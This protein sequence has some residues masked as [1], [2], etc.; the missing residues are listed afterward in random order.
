MT[1]E[2]WL[3]T[4][5]GGGGQLALVHAVDGAVGAHGA[6]RSQAVEDLARLNQ[7]FTGQAAREFTV[8]LQ[9]K[10]ERESILSS[11]STQRTTE[12]TQHIS[13]DCSQWLIY[14][15]FLIIKPRSTQI[16]IVVL[17]Q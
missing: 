13:V 12:L 3:L 11:H 7:R 14:I 9:G 15:C 2:L 5:E 6:A 17:P 1:G 16:V 10:K 8:G 4:D